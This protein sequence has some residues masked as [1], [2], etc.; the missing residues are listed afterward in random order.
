[1]PAVAQFVV[2]LLIQYLSDIPAIKFSHENIP[3]GHRVL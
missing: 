1:M 3:L 2:F